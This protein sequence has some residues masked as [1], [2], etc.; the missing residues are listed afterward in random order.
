MG[1][2]APNAAHPTWGGKRAGS[3]RK[4]APG[5]VRK[6]RATFTLRPGDI[7]LLTRLGN[8]N[9]SAGLRTLIARAERAHIE[10]MLLP[11]T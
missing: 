2:M 4:V 9:V 11:T 7:A 8:G 10:P 3:G 5:D 1:V 6:V